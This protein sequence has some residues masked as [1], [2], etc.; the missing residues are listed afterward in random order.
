[1]LPRRSYAI[2]MN[3]AKQLARQSVRPALP[4]RFQ[5]AA[6]SHGNQACADCVDLSAVENASNK[7]WSLIIQPLVLGFDLVEERIAQT[8]GVRIPLPRSLVGGKRRRPQRIRA[9]AAM[10]REVERSEEH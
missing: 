7:T 1:M 10:H 8:V 6:G 4:K 3:S 5:A 2:R 9:I